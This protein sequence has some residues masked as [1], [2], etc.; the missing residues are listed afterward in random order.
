MLAPDAKNRFD[1]QGFL[2]LTG[3]F[4]PERDFADVIR[5]YDRILDKLNAPA[6]A[7]PL[8][9]DR[10]GERSA[11]LYRTGGSLFAQHFD[12]TLPPRPSIPADTP[13]C[14]DPAIFSLLIHPRLL[15]VVEALIGPEIAL[16]PVCHVRIKPPQVVMDHG[17]DQDEL[18]RK[19]N[20]NDRNGLVSE[21]PWHQDN[22]VFTEDVDD[23]DILTVWFPITS[24]PIDKGCLKIVPGSHKGGL[25]A[26]CPGSTSDLAIPDALMTDEPLALPMVAGDVLF[27]H[28]KTCHGSLP[29]LT[30]SARFSFDLRFQPLGTPNGRDILPSFPLR[31]R[32]APAAVLKDAGVWAETWREA[33]EKLSK[34]EA[35]PP[36]NRW[37]A[38]S[39]MCA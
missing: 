11:D 35:L 30:R 12:I 34:T 7:L 15:D 17:I 21:T 24:A 27:L 23:V 26:H 31:S 33:R 3:L 5:A 39:P 28:R 9:A 25:R 29:N 6:S 36:M 2:L 18:A 13:I 16:N 38:D 4:E 32:H 20:Q 37:S 14:L 1:E 22:A 19:L 10:I 8:S